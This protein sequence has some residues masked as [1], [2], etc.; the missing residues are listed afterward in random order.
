MNNKTRLKR[1]NAAHARLMRRPQKKDSD[2]IKRAYHSS[3]L[4]Q[5]KRKGRILTRAEKETQYELARWYFFN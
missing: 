5:Q 2:W 1:S 3:V 4:E